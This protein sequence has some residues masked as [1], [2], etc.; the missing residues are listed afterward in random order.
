MADD[1]DGTTGGTIMEISGLNGLG[2]E[3][4]PGPLTVVPPPV[5][6]GKVFAAGE[7]GG[8]FSQA[9]PYLI[10]IGIAFGIMVL[11]ARKRGRGAG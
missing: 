11:L 6:Q 5:V 4:L 1:D 9:A 7:D 8:F 10:P 3:A 2:Q